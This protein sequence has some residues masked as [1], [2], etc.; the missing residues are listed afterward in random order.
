VSQPSS[1]LAFPV[2]VRKPIGDL[3]SFRQPTFNLSTAWFAKAAGSLAD[4]P[5]QLAQHVTADGEPDYMS[6]A[7]QLAPVRDTADISHAADVNKFVVT[8]AGRVKCASTGKLGEDSSDGSIA[9]LQDLHVHFSPRTQKVIFDP[10]DHLRFWPREFDNMKAGLL[11]GHLGVAQVGGFTPTGE[12]STT[13]GGGFELIAFSPVPPQETGGVPAPVGPPMPPPPP[14]PPLEPWKCYQFVTKDY[15]WIARCKKS[16]KSDDE[17]QKEDCETDAA[18]KWTAGHNQPYL[19]CGTC[20]CCAPS[21]E[22]SPPPA[23]GPL[24]P[25]GD[26]PRLANVNYD[27]G[28]FVMLR[29]VSGSGVSTSPP[30]YFYASNASTFELATDGAVTFYQ[31]LLA[32]QQK[33]DAL[34]APG[35][36]VEVPASDQRQVDMA[37]AAML[38]TMNN[39]VGNQPNYGNGAT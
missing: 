9:E 23:P 10:E 6:I 2:V 15:A 29:E 13:T 5:T 17:C 35:M 8:F 28:V 39:F 31:A 24:P 19:G 18:R 33:Y 12:T 14:P 38:A 20:Y 21:S 7:A 36:K 37:T 25:S 34:L 26:L 30:V 11:G 1:S 4:V 27:P 16:G 3:T 22:P 32:V